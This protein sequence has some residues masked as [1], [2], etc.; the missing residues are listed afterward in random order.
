MGFT[1][2]SPGPGDPVT[3]A[4]FRV[5]GTSASLNGLAPISPGVN[6]GQ[7]SI[8]WNVTGNIYTAVIALNTSPTFNPNTN[9][10]LASSCGKQSQSDDCHPTGT[11]ACT[12]NN[13]NVMQCSDGLGPYAAQNLTQFL[14]AGVPL[15]A[16]IV[17]QACN[18]QGN[19]CPTSAAAIQIQ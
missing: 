6:N 15:N 14:S 12:F 19:S 7:F 16:Y 13:T 17:I 10:V 2:C 4:S 18:H 8:S 3:I 5:T 11:L 9:I 1:S